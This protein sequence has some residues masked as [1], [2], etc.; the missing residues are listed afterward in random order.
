MKYF[1]CDLFSPFFFSSFQFLLNWLEFY[2][3]RWRIK[4]N[5][6]DLEHRCTRPL[7]ALLLHSSVNRN[8]HV[9]LL[10]PD[11]HYEAAAALWKHQDN[12][13][14]IIHKSFFTH[15]EINNPYEMQFMLTSAIRC[16]SIQQFP[17]HFISIVIL[18]ST[19]K[20]NWRFYYEFKNFFCLV[21][22]KIFCSEMCFC[23]V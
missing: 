8:C 7:M 1:A 9:N 17:G 13:I 2:Y 10:V 21:Q 3:G 19:G 4:Y 11:L 15:E 6:S 16:V 20:G 18:F 22:Q 14:N 12:T 23:L 5:N